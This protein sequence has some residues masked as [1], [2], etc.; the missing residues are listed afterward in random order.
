[1]EPRNMHIFA[2]L[3]NDENNH[4]PMKKILLMITL[5]FAMAGCS[6]NKEN[7][8]VIYYSQTGA[9]EQVAREIAGLLDADIVKIDVTEPYTG[10]YNE[11]IARCLKEREAKLLPELNGLNLDLSKYNTVFI[12]YPIWFGT[13]AP[14][15]AALVKDVDFSGKKIVPFCTFGSGGLGASIKDLKAALADSEISNGYGVRNARIAKAPAEVRRFLIENGYL[16]GE[17]EQLPEYSE[18]H[19]VNQEET[20]IFNLA[21]GDYQYPLGT[22]VTVG[23]RMTSAGVDYRY[24]ASGMNPDGSVSE[25]VIYVTVENTPD[26]KPE[27]TEVVR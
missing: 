2:Y 8:L 5:A 22:P 21:C 17:V 14:P 15:I 13:Y 26:A 27:F 24:T 11:T 20:D 23:S 16:E 3:W 18:Q 25:S 9:T 7:M 12:G 4:N 1:M 6:Q 19:P 10:T